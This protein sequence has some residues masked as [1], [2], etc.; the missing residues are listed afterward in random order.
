MKRTYVSLLVPAFALVGCE[1]SQVNNDTPKGLPSK[2]TKEDLVWQGVGTV[3][4]ILA[5]G[6][7]SDTFTES[8]GL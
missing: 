7:L 2:Y 5:V 1:H 4:M 6:A 3:A 8:L